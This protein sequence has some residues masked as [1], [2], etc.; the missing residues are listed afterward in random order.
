MDNVI[1]KA[2]LDKLRAQAREQATKDE[3]DRVRGIMALATRHNLREMGEKHI[4]DGTPI[5]LF[6]GLAL[7]ELH[8]RGSDKPLDTPTTQIGLSQKEAQ[9]FSVARFMRSLI[10]KDDTVAPFEHE[11]AKA[12]REAMAKQGHRS[13]GKGNFLPFEVMQQALP[14]TRV[15]EGRL[16]VGDRVIAQRDLSSATLGA[17][18]NLVATELMAADFITLL[19]NA[20]LVR[21]MGARVLSGLVGNIAIPRQITGVTPGWVAQGAAAT[22]GDASF[23]VLTMTPKTAHAIQDITRDLLLQATPAVEGL[24]RADLI[25]SMGS[26]LDFIALNG[27]GASNQPTGLFNTAGIGSVVGGTNGAAPTWDH[28]VEL[29]SQVANQ[30]AAFGSMGYLTNTRVRGK[31]KRTQK[32]SGTNGQEIWQAAMAGDDSSVFGSVNGYRAG[33]SNNVRSDLTKGSSSGVCS[34]IGYGNWDDLLIGEW[35]AAEL[36]PDEITQAANRIVRMHIYQTVDIG[37]RR[38]QSFSAMLDALHN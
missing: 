37:V 16:M 25:N 19:R 36:L 26:Q 18:G 8:K 27:T 4:H 28:L 3:Q 13:R 29:E 2:E 21:R 34:S 20:S 38:V 31:L 1:D 30:N 11:C 33:V 32:F 10:D 24:V 7:D 17:G 12:V 23:G 6:R 35:G 14:G 15:S 9:G 5:E 22:E